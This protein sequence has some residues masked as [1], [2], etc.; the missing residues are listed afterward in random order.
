MGWKYISTVYVS[1][2]GMKP[3]TLGI[4]KIFDRRDRVETN[5]SLPK[6]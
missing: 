3:G 6:R 1:A 4:E 5:Q 2:S